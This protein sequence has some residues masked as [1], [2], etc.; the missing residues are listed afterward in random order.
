VSP[1]TAERGA[2]CLKDTSPQ[3]GSSMVKARG[4]RHGDLVIKVFLRVSRQMVSLLPPQK[5]SP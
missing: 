5:D 1:P 2:L 3:E 4:L